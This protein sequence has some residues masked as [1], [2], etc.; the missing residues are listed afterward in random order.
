MGASKAELDAAEAFI[1][2]M[3]KNYPSLPTSKIHNFLNMFMT[4]P[5][6]SLTEKTLQEFL[7]RKL[8][9]EGKLDFNGVN[10]SLKK[11][12]GK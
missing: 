10:Y 4:E 12:E 9:A 5:A 3:L 2:G 1:M 7:D 11:E 8:V 6:Y